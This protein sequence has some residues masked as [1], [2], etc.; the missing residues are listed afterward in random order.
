M[1]C[2]V[3]CCTK[4][5]SDISQLKVHLKDVHN[6]KQND[7]Y[8]CPESECGNTFDRSDNFYRHYKKHL[9]K[10]GNFFCEKYLIK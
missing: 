1:K 8:I 3:K 5:F 7:R 4:E 2:L 9:K 6:M 10:I